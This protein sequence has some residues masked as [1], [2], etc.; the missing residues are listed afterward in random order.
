MV[1]WLNGAFG[2]GKTTAAA[3]LHRRLPGSFVYDP[4][5]AGYFLRRNEPKSLQAPDFQDEPLW[6]E[7]NLALLGRIAREYPGT[8]IVPMTLVNPACFERLVGGLRAQGVRVDHYVL[9]AAEQTLYRRLRGRLEG[10]SSWAA[11][12]VGAC[13]E[14]FR[15]PRFATVIET[16]A[17][18]PAQVAERIAGASGLALLPDRRPAPLRWLGRRLETLRHIRG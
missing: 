4:E 6:R 8:V 7:I 11:A 12:R 10:R 15:D 5:N 14:A 16:D 18:S 17:L 2:S 13:I 3:E 9:G 1:L